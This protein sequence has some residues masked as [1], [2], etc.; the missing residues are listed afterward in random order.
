MKIV[1]EDKNG[2][3][4]ESFYTILN[5]NEYCRFQPYGVCYTYFHINESGYKELHIVKEV[6]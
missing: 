3:V 6:A 1:I 5:S 4:I 2:N